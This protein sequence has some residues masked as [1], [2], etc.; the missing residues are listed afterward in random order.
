MLRPYLFLTRMSNRLYVGNLSCDT[1]ED[2]IRQ[3]FTA[4]GEVTDI[5][6][7]KDRETG[8][9]RGYA[10]VTMASIEEAAK[11]IVELNGKI[12]GGRTL[13]V[14]EAEHQIS[15]RGRNSRCD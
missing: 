6:V 8:R 14:N 3:R 9:P 11:A 13:R 10:F 12:F 5:C 15:R 2:T 4:V 1:T 7:V